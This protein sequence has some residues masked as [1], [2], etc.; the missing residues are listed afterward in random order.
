M[1]TVQLETKLGWKDYIAAV[2]SRLGI[3]RHKSLVRPGLYS[4]GTPNQSSRVF[5]TA[6]YKL[7]VDALRRELTNLNAWILV[8]DTKGINVWCAAG[9]GT[10]GTDEL[11][12]R[13]KE[14]NLADKISHK[15]LIL[16]QL[17]AVGVSAHK[18]RKESGYK[19]IYG[20]IKA[21]EIKNFLS[22]NNVAEKNMREVTFSFI[23]RL[24]LTPVEIKPL[25]GKSIWIIPSILFI[26]AIGTG[27]LSTNSLWPRG[28]VAVILYF[29]GVISG[30]FLAPAL[31]PWVPNRYFSVKGALVAIIT[32]LITLNYFKE[33]L[34]QMEI[35]ALILFAS[36]FSSYI[37]L[38][39]TGSTPFTSPSG[40]EKEMRRAIPIQLLALIISITLWIYRGFVR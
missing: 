23:E 12:N 9:K 22:N 1:Y 38:N 26:S 34:T 10:F 6:N 21:S 15:E 20:P 14:A 4:V 33:T 36:S 19:V 35:I 39:F 27:T 7:S 13:I 11:I 31:L 8:L 40:V 16:P 29:V 17:G 3:G 24:I 5:V 2:K 32:S 28:G 37:A 25:L 18:V 30:A